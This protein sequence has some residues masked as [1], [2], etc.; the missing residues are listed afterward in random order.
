[1]IR[2][3]SPCFLINCFQHRYQFA[4]NVFLHESGRWA[5]R[6]FHIF[7]F[8]TEACK[9]PCLHILLCWAKL[10]VVP[11]QSSLFITANNWMVLFKKRLWLMLLK[12]W[13]A[14]N[15]SSMSMSRS[16]GKKVPPN[17]KSYQEQLTVVHTQLL[18]SVFH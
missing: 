8:S 7:N 2:Q 10:C 3:P 11:F 17:G 1:M 16:S 14:P 4:N 18:L 5:Q 6:H 9:F 15:Q 13:K 12:K